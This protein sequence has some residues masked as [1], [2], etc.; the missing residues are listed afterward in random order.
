MSS[1]CTRLALIAAPV[2]RQTNA[3]CSLQSITAVFRGW[4]QHAANPPWK[5]SGVVQG[6][7][8]GAIVPRPCWRRSRCASS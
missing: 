3:R 1:S 6:T 2:V 5:P 7:Q 8:S 4:G